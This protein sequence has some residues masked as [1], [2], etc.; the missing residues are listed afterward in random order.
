MKVLI[1]TLLFLGFAQNSSAM[2][3]CP[4][5]VDFAVTSRASKESG[6]PCSVV[7]KKGKVAGAGLVSWAVDLSC[8]GRAVEADVITKAMGMSGCVVGKITFSSESSEKVKCDLTPEKEDALK[9]MRVSEIPYRAAELQTIKM[10]RA[11]K[12]VVA[13]V[14]NNSE[15][16]VKELAEEILDQKNSKAEIDRVINA[17]LNSK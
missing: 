15:L 6:K 7:S 10:L 13:A 16:S 3:G 14:K 4:D 2:I 9:E 1:S 12:C 11:N 8:G 5:T 17:Y